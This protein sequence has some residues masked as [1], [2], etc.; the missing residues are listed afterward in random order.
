[1]KMT[2]TEEQE[3]L[4]DTVKRFFEKEAPIE[5]VRQSFDNQK[6]HDAQLWDKISQSGWN[7]IQIEEKY[8]GADGTLI[9]MAIIM[10]QAGKALI[11]TTFYS[12]IYA[13]LLL[14]DLA[15]EEQKGTWLPLIA[16]GDKVGT[17]AF[18]EKHALSNPQLLLTTA[19]KSEDGWILNGE[20]YFVQQAV[21]ADFILVIAKLEEVFG[22]FVVNCEDDGVEIIQQ[23][24]M[25]GNYFGIV[26][27]TNTFV[28]KDNHIGQR[29]FT[30]DEI[31]KSRRTMTALQAVELAGGCEKVVEM[32]VAYVKER[33]QF[34]VAIGTFQAVQHHLSNLYTKAVGA[35]L[36][37]Y[38]AISFI[39]EGQDASREVSI[40]KL[41]AS[42]AYV[43]ITVMAHQLWAG[44]GYSTES[45]LFLWSNRAKTA[46]LTF[47][48]VSYHR[49]EIAKH[50][51]AKAEVHVK[52]PIYV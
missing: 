40:A 14:K 42:N 44:M 29:L 36:A 30:E 45:H 52:N 23:H 37:A 31:L 24:A 4:R 25:D 22:V 19:I 8:G 43:D 50:I 35:R 11:P 39:Q 7:A 51:R 20:K 15:S 33:K 38:K 18:E 26:K 1:M 21:N 49:K 34:G 12:T 16:N 2:F 5:Q 32:T 48:S 6:N 47:G 3:M 46:Q 41:Y 28:T 13:K 10:E 9:D 27:L 17:V